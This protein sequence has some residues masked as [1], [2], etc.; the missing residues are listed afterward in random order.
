M[1]KASASSE[2]TCGAV[3][4]RDSGDSGDGDGDGRCGDSGEKPKCSGAS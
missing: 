4:E 2:A 1:P 3:A